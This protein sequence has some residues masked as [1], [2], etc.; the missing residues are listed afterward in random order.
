MQSAFDQQLLS[1]V[2]FGEAALLD[3]LVAD[4][5]DILDVIQQMTSACKPVRQWL[6]LDVLLSSEQS[7]ALE[8]Q[9]LQP[10]VVFACNPVATAKEEF[11][12]SSRAVLSGY[13]R[14]FQD[15]LFQSA[16]DDLYLLVGRGG[17][18]WISVD[19][20]GAL[21]RYVTSASIAN[22]NEVVNVGSAGAQR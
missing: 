16:D 7:D 2:L 8:Q 14:A 1:D 6:V 15:Y 19:A 4:D 5:E 20:L 3:G 12:S 18:K 10:S 11:S 13:Q 21:K 22:E 9:G 17:R